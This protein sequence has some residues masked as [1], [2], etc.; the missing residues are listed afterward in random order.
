MEDIKRII[1]YYNRTNNNLNHKKDNGS[2]WDNN[3]VLKHSSKLFKVLDTNNE[4]IIS[5]VL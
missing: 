2:I 3:I 1:S 4:S 5:N